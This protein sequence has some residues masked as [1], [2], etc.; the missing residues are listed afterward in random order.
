[1]REQ[2][3]MNCCRK[4]DTNLADQ[5]AA[6]HRCEAFAWGQIS[7]ANGNDSGPFSGMLNG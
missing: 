1:V 6:P 7:E 4:G 2:N 3:R 5:D